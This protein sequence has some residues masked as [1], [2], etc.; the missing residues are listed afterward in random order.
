MLD[1]KQHILPRIFAIRP[2]LKPEK[3]GG[4]WKRLSRQSKSLFKE[5]KEEVVLHF[6]CEAEVPHL[7]PHPGYEFTRTSDFMREYGPMVAVSLRVLQYAI[8]AVP[9]PIG[10]AIP[11]EIIGAF[12]TNVDDFH[13]KLLEYTVA[14]LDK[15]SNTRTYDDGYRFGAKVVMDQSMQ[16]RFKGI[17]LFGV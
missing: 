8:K 7:A 16:Q 14:M 4:L 15:A 17:L 9:L 1:L 13:K 2:K 6:Y 12:A 3:E 10:E 5:S 11:T